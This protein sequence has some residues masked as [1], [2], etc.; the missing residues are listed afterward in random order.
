MP[1]PFVHDLRPGKNVTLGWKIREYCSYVAEYR[2][3]PVRSRTPWS[4]GGTSE[5]ISV[6]RRYA[7]TAIDP[8]GL[9]ALAWTVVGHAG[10]APC[11]SRDLATAPVRLRSSAAFVRSRLSPS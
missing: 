6:S 10:G 9:A 4:G 1:A 3:A 5:C 7:A 8:H 11:R 2:D